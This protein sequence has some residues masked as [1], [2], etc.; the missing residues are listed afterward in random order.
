MPVEDHSEITMSTNMAGLVILAY[1]GVLTVAIAIPIAL[2][3]IVVA[4]V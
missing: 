1:F 4:L 2:I 3:L